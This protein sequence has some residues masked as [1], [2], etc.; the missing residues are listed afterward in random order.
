[1]ARTGP[2]QIITFY[3]YKGGT[4]RTM[5]L[6]NAGVLLARGGHRVLLMDWDLEA[7]GLHRY[8]ADRT[9]FGKHPGTIDL[10]EELAG[11]V[12][13]NPNKA[14]AS[15]ELQRMSEEQTLSLVRDIDL[16]R[17]LVT[18]EDSLQLVWAGASELED[19]ARRVSEFDWIGLHS[20]APYLFTCLAEVLSERF[21]YVCVDSRTGVS[22]TSGV[23]TAMLPEKLVVVFTPNRQ[24][25]DGALSRAR[26]AVNYR[27]HSSDLR[28]LVV[29]PLASRVELSEDDLRRRWR[30]GG[31][32]PTEQDLGY[33][34]RFERLF[35]EMYAMPGC[36]LQAWFDEVQ[37]QQATHYA[38]GEEV[39]AADEAA[40]KDRLSIAYSYARFT[41]ALKDTDGPW[42]LERATRGMQEGGVDLGEIAM[43]RLEDELS[44]HGPLSRQQ[45]GRLLY[46]RA[47]QVVTVV[48]GLVTGTILSG[49]Q[50]SVAET[51]QNIVI[52]LAV[53]ALVVMGEEALA[54]MSGASQWSLHATLARRL[55]DE[56]YSFQTRTRQYA[57]AEDRDKRLAERI[58]DILDEAYRDWENKYKR[59]ESIEPTPRRPKRSRRLRGDDRLA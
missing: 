44:W 47:L 20:R 38:Y 10:L 11:L 41:E 53:A 49:L 58:E 2:G 18:V 22:D 16:E 26:S 54:V 27:R 19:Y 12:P 5:A 13:S 3:S 59:F 7:P 23:C 42:R 32:G 30:Q 34:L 15:R 36:D 51:F 56:E 1:M 6:A 46:F 25:L 21:G 50:G 35:G 48:A 52:A 14:Q 4:G 9:G 40:T 55:E 33:Q 43:R 29:Y 57:D 8:F 24:S 28:P 45:R 17:Y 39:A 31:S 37:I